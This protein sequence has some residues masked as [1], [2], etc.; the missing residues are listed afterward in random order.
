MGFFLC[1]YTNTTEY[2]KFLQ[3]ILSCLFTTQSHGVIIH[4]TCTWCIILLWIIYDVIL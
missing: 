3:M 2:W 4:C 1:V